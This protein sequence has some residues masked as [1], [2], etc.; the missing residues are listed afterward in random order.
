K[1]GK[2]LDTAL[3]ASVTGEALATL[4]LI[5]VAAPISVLSLKAGP[6]EKLFLLI[7]AYTVI[8]TMAGKSIP[9]GLIS[10]CL[11]MLFAM[12]GMSNITGATRFTFGITELMSGISF[13]PMLLG[14]LVMP[15]VINVALR[16]NGQGSE[17][18]IPKPKK[19]ADGRLSFREYLSVFPTILKSTGIGTFIGALPGLGSSTAAFI[20]Y[21]EARRTTKEPQKYGKGSVEGIAAAESANNA[22]CG[23]SLIPMLTLGIPGDDVA[24]LL[25]GAFLIH[26]LTP[27][28]MI[29]YESTDIIYA[30]F[31]GFLIT[32]IFLLVIARSGF[33]FFIKIASL[34]RFYIFPCV[35]V[36]AVVGAY[37]AGQDMNDVLILI[38]FTIFGFLM[39]K[40]DLNPALF[41]IG[42]VLAPFLEQNLDQSLAI[43]GDQYHLLFASPIALFFIFLSAVFVLSVVRLRKREAS[44]LHGGVNE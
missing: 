12:V 42:F 19:P 23:S 2:A 9:K 26:G 32:D 16:R 33:K 13:T 14:V 11:G 37:A 28:P 7:F 38:V 30:I 31:A 39:K 40:V 27:G 43:V 25:M 10:C 3:F 15:E 34:P 5:L 41:I 17:V 20:A 24:A 8:G 18:T 22:V 21:G 44:K 29:F 35:T 36:F 6:I 1:A 4:V